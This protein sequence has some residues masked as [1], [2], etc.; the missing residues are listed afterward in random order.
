MTI[1]FL[2]MIKMRELRLETLKK[3]TISSSYNE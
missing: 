1:Y 3:K 2:E